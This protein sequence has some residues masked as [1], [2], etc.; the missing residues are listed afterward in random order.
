MRIYVTQYGFW[1]S[2]SV[3][4]FLALADRITAT[5][6]GW[7]NLDEEPGFRPLA[8]RPGT[9][10]KNTEGHY[11]ALGAARWYRVL[12]WTVREWAAAAQELRDATTPT[13]AT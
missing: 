12:D 6:T 11:Y 8:K 1:W 4:A 9:I 2:A 13:G 5:P 7:W 10:G 3:E